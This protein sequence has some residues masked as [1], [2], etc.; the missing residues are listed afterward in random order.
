MPEITILDDTPPWMLD[1]HLVAQM[2]FHDNPFFGYTFFVKNWLINDETLQKAADNDVINLPARAIKALLNGPSFDELD[3]LRKKR[4]RQGYT[5]GFVLLTL[6]ILSKLNKPMSLSR[7][8]R[9]LER[10][11]A[12]DQSSFEDIALYC[13]RPEILESWRTMRPVA[14][15]FCANAII[16]NGVSSQILPP[17]LG[18]THDVLALASSLLAWAS[19][20]KFD[21]KSHAD[22][23]I[24]TE[25]ALTLP[26][27]KFRIVENL[28]VV[29]TES[30]PRWLVHA[31]EQYTNN[32]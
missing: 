10:A 22:Y 24:D 3:V 18:T 12:A 21:S 31:V 4:L 2:L 1:A 23:V 14:H 15:F 29:D 6:W 20:Q 19:V 5:A 30:L 27:D 28:G 9:V 11:K 13:S 25:T 7:V 16:R 8:I 26:E 17:E 32:N